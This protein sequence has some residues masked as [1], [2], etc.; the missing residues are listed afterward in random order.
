MRMGRIGCVG[1][2]CGLPAC[3]GRRNVG[4]VTVCVIKAIPHTLLCTHPAARSTCTAAPVVLLRLRR[5]S[6]REEALAR[7]VPAPQ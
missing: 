6:T 1:C 5:V 2:L 4:C 3:A 7:D